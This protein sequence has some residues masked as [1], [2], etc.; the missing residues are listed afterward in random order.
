MLEVFS[1]DFNVKF[2]VVL[3]DVSIGVE[4][5]S[6]CVVVWLSRVSCID[7]NECICSFDVDKSAF[8]F[9]AFVWR[10][11]DSEIVYDGI[12]VIVV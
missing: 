12:A 8:M 11:S 1:V 4:V 6:D 7:Y 10:A 9:N 5:P 3:G 2:S